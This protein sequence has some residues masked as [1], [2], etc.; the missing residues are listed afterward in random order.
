MI[1]LSDLGTRV[2]KSDGGCVA[3]YTGVATA[4]GNTELLHEM[5]HRG[6]YISSA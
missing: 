5:C 1:T 6:M 3:A 2:Y 4:D